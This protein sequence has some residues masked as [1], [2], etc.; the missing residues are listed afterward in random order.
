MQEEMSSLEKNNTYEMVKLP[1]GRKVLKNRWVFKLKK[2]NSKKLMKHKAW[3]V[4][5]GFGEKKGIN[6]DEIISP[7][8]KMTSVIITLGLVANIDLEL[9]QMDV[10]TTCL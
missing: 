7:I 2:D 3:L 9:E 5:K 1:K 10:K 4:V 6:F 8:L